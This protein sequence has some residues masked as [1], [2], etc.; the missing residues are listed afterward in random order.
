VSV[1]VRLFVSE[2]E[3]IEVREFSSFC[4]QV[5]NHHPILSL[6]KGE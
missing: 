3:R 2:G 6:A 4:S 5:F 1:F